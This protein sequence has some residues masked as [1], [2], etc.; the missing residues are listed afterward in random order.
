[1]V[2][3]PHTD[4]DAILL[5]RAIIS[6]DHEALGTLHTRYYSVV[7]SYIARHVKPCEDAND[8]ASEVFF[9]LCQG[10]SRYR[11]GTNAGSYLRGIARRLMGRY[12][13]KQ[14]RQASQLSLGRSNRESVEYDSSRVRMIQ[15]FRM[16]LEEA[17]SLYLTHAPRAAEAIRLVA[18]DHLSLGEAAG[19]AGCSLARFSDRFLYGVRVLKRCGSL[20]S[21]TPELLRGPPTGTDAAPPQ[22]ERTCL[23]ACRTTDREAEK[24]FVRK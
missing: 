20:S 10:K 19:R 15:D 3:D 11:G 4:P 8:L 22:A 23:C 24:F 17:L 5:N 16:D 6:H 2:Q 13:R 21:Y 9:E 14:K 12:F 1:L 7:R 18:I